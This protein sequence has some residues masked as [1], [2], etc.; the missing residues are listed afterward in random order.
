MLK[1][2][3][4]NNIIL[5]YLTVSDLSKTEQ[6]NKRLNKASKKFN[7]KWKEEC[8]D[9]FLHISEIMP[10]NT[11]DNEFLQSIQKMIY[12][13]SKYNFKKIFE[14]GFSLFNDWGLKEI[15]SNENENNV[16]E[17]NQNKQ[18]K[19]SFSTQRNKK[20]TEELLGNWKNLG[21]GK[22]I[23]DPMFNSETYLLEENSSDESK[24]QQD[25]LAIR[26]EVFYA[27]KCKLLLFKL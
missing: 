1:N 18:N 7:Y 21:I 17:K 15:K 2:D 14:K 9:H 8:E 13:N 3:N 6:I 11:D 16:S 23:S 5:E 27:F 20:P 4:I 12:K 19:Q 24:F 22:T 10:L 25:L 26:K